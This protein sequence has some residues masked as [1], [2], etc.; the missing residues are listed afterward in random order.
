MKRLVVVVLLALTVPCLVLA[1][2][3]PAKPGPEHKK[4][5]IW[6]GNWTYEG[7]AKATPLG[8]AG[9]VTGT[10]TTRPVLGG[11]FVE[12]SG[13]E[14]G[15]G[16]AFEWVEI[17][18]YDPVAKLFTWNGFQSDGVVA[19]VTYTLDGTRMTFSGTLQ[20]GGK[21]MKLRGTAVFSPDFTSSVDKRE[22][23]VDGKTW[24]PV[25]EGKSTKVK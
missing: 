13:Q 7:E 8:P 22:V 5:G 14:K 4:L 1:Q 6:V 9:K 2:T 12:F 17:D 3:A 19:V 23:S 24:L 25:Y 21:L 18:G 20:A 10:Y 16:G 11:F 15:P